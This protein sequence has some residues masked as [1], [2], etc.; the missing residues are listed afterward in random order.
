MI[1]LWILLGIVSFI[2]AFV[3][4]SIICSYLVNTKKEYTKV[5]KFYRWL[6]NVW[7]GIIVK[8]FRVKVEIS[9]ID[10]VPTDSRFLVVQNHKSGFDAIISSYVFRKFNVAYISKPENFKIFCFGRVVRKCCFLS[11]DRENPRNAIV[12]ISKASNLI[13]NDEASIGI[14][15]EGTRNK[16]DSYELLPFH[17]G[18][19][20]IAQKGNVPIVI[21]TIRGSEN[22]FKNYPLKRTI[23]KVDILDVIDKEVV[24]DSSTQF[25]GDLVKEV[26]ENN[27]LK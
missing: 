15:P 14:Y 9:G 18:T 16:S 23:V 22:I 13:L 19:L 8:I 17:N 27:L 6:L 21:S 3:L 1:F 5:N 11:I 26:M 10:K 12:T 7:V 2:I 4:F 24:V 25:L 20:K